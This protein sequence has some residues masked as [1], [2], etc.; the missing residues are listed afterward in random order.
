MQT[1]KTVKR[2]VPWTGRYGPPT[3][4]P[5][6]VRLIRHSSGYIAVHTPLSCL[7]GREDMTEDDLIGMLHYS[8]ATPEEATTEAKRTHPHYERPENQ[9][10]LGRLHDAIRWRGEFMGPHELADAIGVSV[11]ELYELARGGIKATRKQ[12]EAADKYHGGTG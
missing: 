9:I 8:F 2:Y 11:S 1:L 12:A 6:E 5:A 3:A 4:Y 10:V 7:L